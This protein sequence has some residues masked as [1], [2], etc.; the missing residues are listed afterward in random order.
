MPSH[1]DCGSKLLLVLPSL[2]G[3]HGTD[4]AK[5]CVTMVTYVCCGWEDKYKEP[6]IFEF[7]CTVISLL[8][9]DESEISSGSWCDN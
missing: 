6:N 1:H 4:K 9:I 7:R 2:R 5:F 8:T 3:L